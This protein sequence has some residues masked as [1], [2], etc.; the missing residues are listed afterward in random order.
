M[1]T[2]EQAATELAAAT[3]RARTRRRPRKPSFKGTWWRHLVA[4]LAIAFSLFPAVYVLSAAFNADQSLSGSSLIPR[5]VTLDNFRTILT[6]PSTHYLRW[7]ANSLIVAGLTALLTVLL[8]ALAAYAFSR[9]RF[10]GRRRV[11]GRGIAAAS[12]V[13]RCSIVVIA[14]S[15]GRGCAR[16]RARRS[17][18]R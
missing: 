12:S 8:G 7:F 4:L 1:T 5:K 15:P 18:P 11:F 9:F 6:D 2:I 16:T 13:A 3:P 10:R 14:R 17:S